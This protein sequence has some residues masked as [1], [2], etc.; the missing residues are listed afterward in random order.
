MITEIDLHREHR[1]QVTRIIRKARRMNWFSVKHS[2]VVSER[3]S[4]WLRDERERYERALEV[5]RRRNKERRAAQ[6]DQAGSWSETKVTGSPEAVAVYGRVQERV[7][8]DGAL[9]RIL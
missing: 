2:A 3:M 8:V 9:L 6:A 5:H 1:R 4:V 7:A